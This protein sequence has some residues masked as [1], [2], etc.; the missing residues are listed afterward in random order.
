MGRKKIYHTQKE[1]KDAQRKW[2]MEYY[3]RNRDEIL[4]KARKKYRDKKISIIKFKR[5]KHYSR[6]AVTDRI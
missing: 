1:K 2:Q 4:E 6:I 5:R 3:Q